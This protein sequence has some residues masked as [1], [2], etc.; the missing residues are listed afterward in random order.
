[1]AIG[2]ASARE[3]VDG[4]VSMGVVMSGVA[5]LGFG[6]NK[7]MKGMVMMERVTRIT[8]KEVMMGRV[9]RLEV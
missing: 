5:T 7:G 4:L 8:I 9:T 1:M 3:M 2:Y 6:N